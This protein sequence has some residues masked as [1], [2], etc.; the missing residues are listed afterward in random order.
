MALTHFREGLKFDPE[1]KGCKEGHKQ[2][3]RCVRGCVRGV[4]VVLGWGW[5]VYVTLVFGLG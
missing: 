1:H 5:W 4:E 2:V 3:G